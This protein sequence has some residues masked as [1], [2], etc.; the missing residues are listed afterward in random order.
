MYHLCNQC[1]SSGRN[2]TTRVAAT[3]MTLH[4]AAHGESL[5]TTS[6]GAAERL[7]ARVRVGVNAQGR[8]AR[9][10]LV[11]C[12]TDISVVV[13]LIWGRGA[14]REVVVMLPGGSDWRD[15]RW[16]RGGL[17]L[18]LR[19]G[20]LRECLRLRVNWGCGR[21]SRRSLGDWS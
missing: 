6:V 8:R 16:R 7:L 18:G 9:E 15:E 11:T 19:L 12:T 1:R 20:C 14:W 2:S 21:C 13:L 17:G 4:V 3:L 10:C 5:A